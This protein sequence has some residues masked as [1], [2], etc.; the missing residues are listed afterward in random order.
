VSR[1]ALTR[2]CRPASLIAPLALMLVLFAA[3][4][5][6]AS[7]ATKQLGGQLQCAP[8][9][10]VAGIWMLGSKSG[11]HGYDYPAAYSQRPWVGEYLITATRGEAIQAW[12]RCAVF[13]ESYTSFTVGSG[14]TRHICSKGWGPCVSTGLG[15]CALRLVFG[16]KISVVGCILRHGR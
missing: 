16:N 5:S 15:G 12:I 1:F 6:G 3:L 9:E 13:G 14:S 8:G 4:A 2:M 10:K 11:W 7:A